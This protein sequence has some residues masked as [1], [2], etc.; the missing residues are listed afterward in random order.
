MLLVYIIYNHPEPKRQRQKKSSPVNQSHQPNR[1]SSRNT[2]NNTHLNSAS[3]TRHDV[4]S[5]GPTTHNTRLDIPK[6]QQCDSHDRNAIIQRHE[7]FIRDEIRDQRDK[8]ADEVANGKG[9]GRDPR[10]VAVRLRL[11]V[12]EGDEEIKEAVVR[13][14]QRVVELGYRIRGDTMCGKDIVDDRGGFLRRGFDQFLGFAEGGFIRFSVLFSS[15][16]ISKTSRGK[17]TLHS[18]PQH[19]LPVPSKWHPP[20]T[21]PTLLQPQPWCSPALTVPHSAQR[22]LS[23]HPRDPGSHLRQSGD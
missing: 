18:S 14:M 22:E 11:F 9:D 21:P 6:R 23:I 17:H 3:N 12:V 8:P 7:H 16:N 10:L 19:N 4:L 5:P 20:S 2:S 13:G 15:A 1:R